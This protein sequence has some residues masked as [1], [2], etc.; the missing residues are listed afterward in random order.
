MLPRTLA[1]GAIHVSETG[2]VARSEYYSRGIDFYDRGLY[3]EA[4]A[5]FERVLKTIPSKDAP[6]RK[7]ASFYMGESYANLGLAH[8]HMRNL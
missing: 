4:I 7:L 6:E 1:G 2:K 8:F 5:E 3:T